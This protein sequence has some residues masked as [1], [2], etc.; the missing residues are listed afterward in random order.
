MSTSTHQIVE[1]QPFSSQETVEAVA[2]YLVVAA[3][4]AP[5]VLVALAASFPGYFHTSNAQDKLSLEQSN[6]LWQRIGQADAMFTQNA[7]ATMFFTMLTQDAIAYTKR[8]PRLATV[9]KLLAHVWAQQAGKIYN[10]AYQADIEGNYFDWSL[11]YDAGLSPDEVHSQLQDLKRNPADYFSKPLTQKAN[12]WNYWGSLDN[13]YTDFSGAIWH[14]LT[15][16]LEQGPRLHEKTWSDYASKLGFV[17]TLKGID[18]LYQFALVK[19]FG[20]NEKKVTGQITDPELRAKVTTALLN[21]LYY[22]IEHQADI[23]F[24]T[25]LGYSYRH[26]DDQTAISLLLSGLSPKQQ[27]FVH[28]LTTQLRKQELDLAALVADIEHNAGVKAEYHQLLASLEEQLRPSASLAATNL[29]TSAFEAE[30]VDTKALERLVFLGLPQV[31][32]VRLTAPSA[33][34]DQ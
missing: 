21:T 19:H 13:K 1:L 30:Q 31:K 9:G 20:V 24:L 18:L 16:N 3:G 23:R 28:Q 2:K 34:N 22:F 29:G 10:Q 11:R 25:S 15:T 33:R 5:A 26:T 14:C 6:M 32:T 7:Q 8:F 4:Q 27:V 12:L 17:G